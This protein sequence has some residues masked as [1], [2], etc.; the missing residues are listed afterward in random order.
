MSYQ[1][2]QILGSQQCYGRSKHADKRAGN[3]YHPHGIYSVSTFDSYVKQSTAFGEW[4]KAEHGCKTIESCQPYITEYLDHYSEGKSNS[5]VH[6]AKYSIQKLYDALQ[7]GFKVDYAHGKRERALITKNRSEIKDVKDFNEVKHAALIE[8]GKAT[9]LRRHELL[10]IRSKDV[11][12]EA[13]T[14]VVKGKGG[15][16]RELKM[17]EIS[18]HNRFIQKIETARPDDLVFQKHDVPSRTPEHRCRRAY[19]QELYRQLARPVSQIPKEDRYVCRKDKAGV[20]YDKKAMRIVSAN[21][22]HGRID[23]IANNYL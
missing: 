13:G 23:V 12:L 4:C 5:S 7:P 18:P 1:V 21:L 8:F 14:I 22:G 15:K 3:D 2:K 16:V 10:K 6:T 17:L 20:I 11:N 19:A 9:G